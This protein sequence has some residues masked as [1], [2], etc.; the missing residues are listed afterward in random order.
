MR[1]T[2]RGARMFGCMEQG[3]SKFSPEPSK[4]TLSRSAREF[5]QVERV[6]IDKGLQLIKYLTPPCVA[7]T[8]EL[9][10]GCIPCG[11]PQS[12][13]GGL[14]LWLIFED[15]GDF[16]QFSGDPA[17]KS[18]KHWLED[19]VHEA[20]KLTASQVHIASPMKRCA[21]TPEMR[22]W[23]NKCKFI[24]FYDVQYCQFVFCKAKGQG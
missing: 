6:M 19:L 10:A 24:G 22:Q 11:K 14:A 8:R 17:L 23:K 20:H 9:F 12:S 16:Q 7:F 15:T 1:V 2:H 4:L 21:G 13:A 3:L 5:K 18:A